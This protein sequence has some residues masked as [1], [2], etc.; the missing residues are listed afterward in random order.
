MI[1]QAASVQKQATIAVL[2]SNKAMSNN[3]RKEKKVTTHYNHYK[4]IGTTC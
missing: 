2:R 4:N 1:F 3:N